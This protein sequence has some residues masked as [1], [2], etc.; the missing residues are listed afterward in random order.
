MESEG[1]SHGF[2]R[3]EGSRLPWNALPATIT[4]P[5]EDRLGAAIVETV[6][7]SGGFSPG[8]AARI[9]LSDERKA[10][11]KAVATSSDSD[12]PRFHR[13]E[14]KI[15]AA[16]PPEA[17]VPRFLFAIDDGEWIALA[18]EDIEGEGP[19]LPW[20]TSELNRVLQAMHDLSE[21]LTPSPIPSDARPEISDISF[22]FFG[23]RELAA[24]PAAE[25][26][27]WTRRNLQRLVELESD[28]AQ[29]ARGETLV[30]GDVRADNILLTPSRVL[31][32][33]WPHASIGAAWVD[34]VFFLPSVAMQRGPKPWEIFQKHPLGSTAPPE[35]VDAVV[36]AVAGFFLRRGSL[37]SPPGL[38][39]L[40]EFAGA[41]GI[42][43]MAWLRQRLTDI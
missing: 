3:A 7:Q 34:L 19:R 41:Q 24:D 36:A 2:P 18:F 15:A 23:W 40:R 27:A 37:P 39:G 33:D 29:A 43:A 17:P 38:P 4:G 8:V 9:R 14:A 10:F 22:P 1:P 35:R 12:A 5:L 11:V 21:S 20:Q 42:E 30:H 32:V 26:D 13:R 28:W 16:L 25:L 6:T 31:F